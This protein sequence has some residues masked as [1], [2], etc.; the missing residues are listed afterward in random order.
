MANKD[1]NINDFLDTTMGL[2]GFSPLSELKR[3]ELKFKLAL[4]D[5]KDTIRTD[6][7]P[8]ALDLVLEEMQPKTGAVRT[9]SVRTAANKQT[10]PRCSAVMCGVKISASTDAMYCSA[11][12][13]TVPVR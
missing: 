4:A 8:L 12:H 6:D 9:A 7:I 2:Y 10:C 3:R 5:I 1:K 11:C 13:V